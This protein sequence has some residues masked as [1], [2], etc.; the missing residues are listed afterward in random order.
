VLRGHLRTVG[1]A[2]VEHI[3]DAGQQIRTACA[4]ASG[5]TRMTF[6]TSSSKFDMCH[7]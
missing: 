6:T 3:V 5:G 1:V 7:D 2:E 4:L